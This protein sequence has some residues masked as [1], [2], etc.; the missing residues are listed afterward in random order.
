MAMTQVQL[1]KGNYI[2]SCPRAEGIASGLFNLYTN[3]G[4]TRA[5]VELTC[6]AIKKVLSFMHVKY[7]ERQ[8]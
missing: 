1:F 6:A 7:G 3:P 4:I 8:D 2:C 5:Y